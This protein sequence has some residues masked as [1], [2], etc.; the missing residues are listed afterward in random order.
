MF[1]GHEH[2]DREL[3]AVKTLFTAESQWSER[4]A[5]D[6]PEKVWGKST[7]SEKICDQCLSRITKGVLVLLNLLSGTPLIAL[8]G[9]QS[10]NILRVHIS[11]AK[12]HKNQTH[13]RLVP[14]CCTRYSMPG[15]IPPHPVL[16]AT[17]RRLMWHHS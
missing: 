5:T 8:L 3:T 2:E 13:H 12:A 11:S 14:P 9:H 15:H 6:R 1:D 7:I 16:W 17:R 4:S 10:I